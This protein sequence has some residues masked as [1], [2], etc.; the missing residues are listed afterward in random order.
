MEKITDLPALLSFLLVVA[1]ILSTVVQ[2]ITELTK[3]IGPLKRVSTELQVILT[4]L[5]LTP[6]TVLALLQYYG[7]A[8]EWFMVFASFIAAFVIAYVSMYGWEK[9][10]GIYQRMKGPAG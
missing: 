5:V 3:G 6:A 7:I 2:V 10:N 8:V 4:S 1:G 9:L